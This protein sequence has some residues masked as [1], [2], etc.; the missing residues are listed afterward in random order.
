MRALNIL[1]AIACGCA[2]V[3]PTIAVP[4]PPL[5]PQPFV[6]PEN[7]HA[8]H[9]MGWPGA[10]EGFAYKVIGG[11]DQGSVVLDSSVHMRGGQAFVYLY[12]TG[13]P[14]F[15]NPG[16]FNADNTYQFIVEGTDADGSVAQSFV[17][18]VLDE[19]EPP[20]L[21]APD[22][23]HDIFDVQYSFEDSGLTVYAFAATDQ[24]AGDSVA[25]AIDGGADAALFSVDPVDGRLSLLAAIDPQNPTDSDGDGLYEVTVRASDTHGLSVAKTAVISTQL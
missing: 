23:E 2:C 16:D 11:D 12:L 25:W 13:A 14:D 6:N 9:E 24:D 17:I 10:G 22:S 8:T 21:T 15:E 4:T 1:L 19:N 20:V 7:F 3:A 5:N 18:Q